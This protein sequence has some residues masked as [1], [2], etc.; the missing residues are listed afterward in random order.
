L[1]GAARGKGETDFFNIVRQWL[2]YR[3]MHLQFTS[4]FPFQSHL[5]TVTHDLSTRTLR[6]LGEGNV[7]AILALQDLMTITMNGQEATEENQTRKEFRKTGR[8][9]DGTGARL[10][11]ERGW[12]TSVNFAFAC[13]RSCFSVIDGFQKISSYALRIE[14]RPVFFLRAECV[15]LRF[16]AFLGLFRRYPLQKMDGCPQRRQDRSSGRSTEDGTSSFASN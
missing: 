10:K 2:W 11:V 16:S 7:N 5:E 15:L 4:G 1:R 6:D 12:E 9:F 13:H 8:I 3:H 14:R